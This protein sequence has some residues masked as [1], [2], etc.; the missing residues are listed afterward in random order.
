MA[1][2]ADR[3]IGRP[4]YAT[5][6][7]KLS[8]SATGEVVLGWTLSVHRRLGTQFRCYIATRA[9]GDGPAMLTG[10]LAHYDEIEVLPPEVS[11]PRRFYFLV[12]RFPTT[13]TAEG[14]RQ[15]F[16]LPE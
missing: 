15:N 13:A 1:G 6:P 14:A 7:M 4:G 2:E 11:E 12:K 16:V 5:L 3:S 9:G 8:L 10:M